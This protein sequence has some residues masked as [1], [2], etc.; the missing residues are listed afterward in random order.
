[1]R[2]ARRARRWQRRP[3][4]SWRRRAR[5]HRA[6][7]RGS[8]PV[9]PVA[10]SPAAKPIAAAAT[11]LSRTSRA[12]GALTACANGRAPVATRRRSGPGRPKSRPWRRPAR[13]PPAGCRQGTQPPLGDRAGPRTREMRSSMGG[14][15]RGTRAL[16]PGGAVR[17]SRARRGARGCSS[18]KAE[19][20]GQRASSSVPSGNDVKMCLNASR[21][22][23]MVGSPAPLPGDPPPRDC[24]PRPA[25]DNTRPAAPLTTAITQLLSLQD[26]VV[27]VLPA[28]LSSRSLAASVVLD[29]G[30]V[31]ATRPCSRLVR[32]SPRQTHQSS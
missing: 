22:L 12:G 8:G 30:F 29:D 20:V 19:V 21:A 23:T 27:P 18:I 24:H 4:T 16:E 5:R 17:G 9:A 6:G 15:P 25:P 10:D 32:G 28:L 1:M 2:P 14:R 3:R 26:L 31:G 13:E 11:A 7:W